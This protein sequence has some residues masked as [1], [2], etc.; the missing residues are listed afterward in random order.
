MRQVG[1][2]HL[3]WP[4]SASGE[5]GSAPAVYQLPLRLV[6][7]A[8]RREHWGARARRARRE[9]QAAIAIRPHPIPCTVQLIRLAPRAL[10]D[11]N[12]QGAFKSLR[13]GIAD[14]L[15]VDDA[16]P[17]VQWLYSQERGPYGVRIEIHGT[18]TR[19]SGKRP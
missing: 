15:G 18:G 4:Y 17:R 16:D 9:R 12:L 2:S 8:N 5:P 6:S 11:D 14:R 10:D 19:L 7:L 3:P 1:A 13:D